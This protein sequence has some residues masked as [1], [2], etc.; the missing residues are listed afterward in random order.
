MD[1]NQLDA[2]IYYFVKGIIPDLTS[3]DPCTLQSQL[4]QFLDQNNDN[5]FNIIDV[6]RCIRAFLHAP[7][8]DLQTGICPD[9][10]IA[11]ASN[12]QCGSGLYCDASTHRCQRE[13]GF[14]EATST[15]SAT[16]TTG[17]SAAPGNAQPTGSLTLERPCAG[18]LKVCDYTMGKCQTMDLHG[19]TCQIKADCPTGAYC[20]LGTCQPE[21]SRSIECPGSNW[22]CAEDNTCRTV[23]PSSSSHGDPF[24][25]HAYVLLF[26][27]RS[28]SIDALQDSVDMQLLIMNLKTKQPVNSDPTLAFGYRAEIT[29]E[30]KQS[31]VCRTMED[32]SSPQDDRTIADC[33]IDPREE[34]LTVLNPFGVVFGSD[35]S[36]LQFHFNPRAAALLTPGVYAATIKII[37]DNGTSDTATIT[38]RKE[39]TSGEYAGA[40]DLNTGVLSGILASSNVSMRLRIGDQSIPGGGPT[41]T[42]QQLLAQNNLTRTA[43]FEDV[44]PGVLVTGSI[45]A[46]NSVMYANP[47]A[48][49]KA[50]NE[51]PLRG[52][53][54]ERTGRM[55]LIAVID[56]PSTFCITSNGTPCDAAPTSGDSSASNIAIRNHF[57]RNI[58]RVIHFF[59]T[60][61]GVKRQFY[62]VYRETFQ[63]LLPD[64]APTL[65]G[66]FLLR[67][68]TSDDTNGL[69]AMDSTPLLAGAQDALVPFP[70]A[71]PADPTTHAGST[72]AKNTL[73]RQAQDDIDLYCAAELQKSS[74]T[75][76]A[77]VF[78]RSDLR[79]IASK[80]TSVA[81]WAQFYAT[82]PGKTLPD[83]RSSTAPSFDVSTFTDNIKNALNTLKN[84]GSQAGA[85]V[86]LHE[87]LATQVSFCNSDINTGLGLR[88]DLA[89]TIAQCTDELSTRCGLA[90]FRK[91][92]IAGWVDPHDMQIPAPATPAVTPPPS[93]H[94]LFCAFGDKDPTC[95]IAP[96]DSPAS[97][98]YQ[99]YAYY[100]RQMLQTQHFM[101]ANALSNAFYVM[102][103]SAGGGGISSALAID[104]KM[105]SLRTAW[106]IYN[107]MRADVYAPQ[108]TYVAYHWPM[109]QFAGYGRAW[110]QQLQSTSSDSM[111]TLFEIMDVKRRLL[112]NDPTND[113]IFAQH[114]LHIEFVTQVYLYLQQKHWE[115]SSFAYA[116]DAGTLVRRGDVLLAKLDTSRNPLGYY[117]NE[118]YFENS[119]L[120]ESN[121]TNYQ[122]QILGNGTSGLLAVA[123]AKR[124]SAISALRA[125]LQD[126]NNLETNLTAQKQ[127]LDRT[128]D[129]MC[130]AVP[131]P[132]RDT[133]AT[134][135]PTGDIDATCPGGSCP[136]SYACDDPACVSVAQTFQA[137]VQ[138]AACR[139]DQSQYVVHVGTTNRPCNRGQMGV[140]LQEKISLELQRKQVYRKLKTLNDQI[141]NQ[142]SYIQSTQQSNAAMLQYIGAHQ[143][144]LASVDHEMVIANGIF[145]ARSAAASAADCVIGVAANSCP[146]KGIAVTGIVDATIMHTDTLNSVTTARNAADEIFQIG[147]Q[148]GQNTK[149]LLQQR[150]TLDNLTTEVQNLVSEFETIAQNTTN[151]QLRIADTLEQAQRTADRSAEA[152]AHLLY[153][154]TDHLL[155]QAD[156]TAMMS[157]DLIIAS[158]EAFQ[159]LLIATYK[160]TMAFVHA[161]NM[162]ERSQDFTNR[163]FRLLTPD[164]VQNYLHDLDRERRN[165]CGSSVAT[166]DCDTLNNLSQFRF[167]VRDNLF[168]QLRDIVDPKTGKV[169]TAGEQFHS[170][171]TT[172]Y[173]KRRVFD[174]GLVEER[175]EIPF[176]IW[177]NDRG[178]SSKAVDRAL[179]DLSDCN[180]IIASAPPSSPGTMAVIAQGHNFRGPVKFRMFRGN[181]D[182]LRGCSLKTT[183][184]NGIARTSIPLNTYRVG[185][186]SVNAGAGESTAPQFFTET[187]SLTA[188]LQNR[189]DRRATVDDPSCFFYFARDRS[190][191]APD[192]QIYI[193]LPTDDDGSTNYT[194][195][196]KQIAVVDRPII[197]DI[198][199]YFRY[200]AYR[201]TSAAH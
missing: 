107:T 144:A 71:W 85:A 58:R 54:D 98:L 28:T 113:F 87:Y 146:G 163:V 45:H 69:V 184:S 195:R 33:L 32:L 112:A 177:A 63:G 49:T 140:L 50:D 103:S 185:Y 13:C 96:K 200:G 148:S 102:Y 196:D 7:T 194:L 75:P 46:N 188:C 143:A 176:S 153:T 38:Y 80:D 79:F 6:N 99:Q 72:A 168:P 4:T 132:K 64:G 68:F 161:Y 25:P 160:M 56:I 138:A 158:E 149:E 154:L 86:T 123:R 23:P 65:D 67:Q 101:A 92:L 166:N 137:G 37:F 141:S 43:D 78:A 53:Y 3:T 16:N 114:M 94:T 90:L 40:L 136:R 52:T 165:Y 105:R 97:F 106:Q 21:C 159:D 120:T 127:A 187:R 84:N 70:A 125:K 9:H 27:D 147:M 93:L 124:D 139:V 198:V 173:V 2:C 116:G 15:T 57:S 26:T 157:N 10:G 20:F 189:A 117:D 36:A 77:G 83:N 104:R 186:A 29:Y 182:F 151:I 62:G 131:D 119:N 39:S 156:S 170:L 35:P 109:D 197:D 175:I 110:T 171:I 172:Q 128:L 108:A 89:G 44:S 22:F 31:N 60:L 181:M 179:L 115:G 48:T 12:A 61:D 145:S 47:A 59:G 17:I 167:S 14:I 174:N 55:H 42:W 121:T 155:G 126:A 95:D 133:P 82:L 11:C 152:T 199:I 193:P 183:V 91:A 66:S 111:T 8:C 150:M 130:G 122:Q 201:M 134:T 135:C 162:R 191:A 30:R 24:D 164:D 18:N 190:L 34:F 142:V 178:T 180:H 19:S 41:L 1:I 74:Q 129:E 118:V 88:G 5:I 81:D 192:W 169:T 76:A 73:F 100:Y 51:I